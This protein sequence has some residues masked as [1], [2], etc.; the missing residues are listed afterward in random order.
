M[1]VTL[2]GV[3]LVAG[4]LV[5]AGA[6]A[7]SGMCRIAGR[8]V[9]WVWTGALALTV[10]LTGLAPLRRVSQPIAN[11]TSRTVMIGSGSDTEMRTVGSG[12]LSAGLRT[13][14]RAV[15]ASTAS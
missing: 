15:N 3:G 12:G 9:R 13:M 6:W 2:I 5:A 1:I 14:A 11:A 8:P 10:I 7:L 4:L